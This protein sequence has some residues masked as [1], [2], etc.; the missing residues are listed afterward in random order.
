M[1]MP[2]GGLLGKPY[3]S[4]LAFV[5]SFLGNRCS[6]KC[7]IIRGD[8]SI[9]CACRI[10]LCPPSVPCFLFQLHSGAYQVRPRYIHPAVCKLVLFP[11]ADA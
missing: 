4:L 5:R 10:F 3:I 8:D 9:R 1:K 6:C 7:R 2:A 11:A